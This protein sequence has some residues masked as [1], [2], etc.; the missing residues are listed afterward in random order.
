[1]ALTFQRT[2][3]KDLLNVWFCFTGFPKQNLKVL[4]VIWS[5]QHLT[6]TRNS[7]KLEVR[8]CSFIYDYSILK[9]KEFQTVLGM[10]EL[11]LNA[12]FWFFAYLV[13]LWNCLFQ[14]HENKLILKTEQKWRA[15]TSLISYTRQAFWNNTSRCL[16][17][18]LI[19]KKYPSLTT[20]TS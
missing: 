15:I 9:N 1:M 17:E 18:Q 8:R 7:P 20:S 13:C 19:V 3:L 11:D 5:P 12:Q 16:M 4:S 6:R 10:L 14:F 2:F